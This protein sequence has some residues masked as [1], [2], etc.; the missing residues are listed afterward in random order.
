MTDIEREEF[1]DDHNLY[2]AIIVARLSSS[3]LPKKNIMPIVDKPMIE[4]LIE[5]VGQSKRSLKIIIATSDEKSDDP[6]QELANKN[7][8]YCYRGSL[9][10]IMQRIV[11]AANEFNIKNIIEILGDNPLVHGNLIDDVINIFEREKCDY[12]ATATKEYDLLDESIK[13]FS[14]GVRVQIYRTKIGQ[15]F[16]DF[17]EYINNEAKHPCSFIFDNPEK[18]SVKF[19]EAKDDWQ[20]LNKPDLNFAVNYPKNFQFVKSIFETLYPK[21]QFFCLDEMFKYL[22][23]N[24][25]L[26]QLLG[27]E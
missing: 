7:G 15:K 16:N 13:K 19:L 3:R 10:N 11:G 24:Q 25:Q 17:P 14:V 12:A 20:F 4:H 9:N 5:R 8:I 1:R 27:P 23:T 2:G 21:N 22:E 18:F 26:F 6:L